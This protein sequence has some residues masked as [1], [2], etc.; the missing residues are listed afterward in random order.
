MKNTV[1]LTLTQIQ[2]MFSD[3]YARRNAK[4]YSAAHLVLRIYEETSR[5]AEIFRKEADTEIAPNI[6]HF[7]GWLIGFCNNEGIDLAE[8]VFNKYHGACPYCGRAK[9]CS[10]ISRETKVVK[11]RRK[12]GAV[13]PT[14][15]PDWQAMFRKIYGR[16]NKAIGKHK[17]WDHLLEEIG[18]VSKESRHK[19]QNELRDEL[20][21]VFAW[22]IAFCNN[23]GIDLETAILS[24]YPGRCDVCGESK[25]NCPKI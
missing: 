25:C 2:K 10:C 22:L 16:M 18:E 24:H 20:A 13:M 23:S 17:V 6:V 3:I 8:A 11:W 19:R 1:H 5:M 12:E 9:D 15:L 4:I 14:S 7:F 21:D